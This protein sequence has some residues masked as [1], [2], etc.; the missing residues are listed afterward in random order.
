M[1]TVFSN[2]IQS[3][4]LSKR[5]LKSNVTFGDR[6][7]LIIPRKRINAVVDGFDKKLTMQQ[8]IGRFV[9]TSINSESNLIRHRSIEDIFKTINMIQAKYTQKQKYIDVVVIT[10][11]DAAKL[12]L[13]SPEN[14]NIT[15]KKIFDEPFDDENILDMTRVNN[16]LN[17]ESEV[18]VEMFSKGLDWGNIRVTT[19]EPDKIQELKNFVDK[20]ITGLKI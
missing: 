17:N 12:Y 16:D 2:N 19:K 15:A 18:T 10:N 3:S 6:Y 11:E 4:Y 8:F 5:N 9:V 14:K 1:I 7:K 13:A 20:I